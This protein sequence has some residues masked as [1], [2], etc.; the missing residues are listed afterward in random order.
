MKRKT[1]TLRRDKTFAS[2]S[3][4]SRGFQSECDGFFCLLTRAFC[5]R[6]RLAEWCLLGEILKAQNGSP[7]PNGNK[8]YNCLS[9][10]CGLLMNDDIY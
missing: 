10:C 4:T 3:F 6:A 5:P 8:D 2:C 7:V 1:F 9:A